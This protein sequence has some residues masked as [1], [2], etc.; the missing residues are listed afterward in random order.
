MI[1]KAVAGGPLRFAT[2]TE[3]EELYR[4]VL[5]RLEAE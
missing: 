2:K 5:A 4:S 1:S 3:N